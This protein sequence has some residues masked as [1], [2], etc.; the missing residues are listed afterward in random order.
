[1]HYSSKRIIASLKK[2][3][4][5]IVKQLKLNLNSDKEEISMVDMY[6][7]LVMNQRRQISV[8][9]PL[10]M[11]P[12]KYSV[13]VLADLNALGLDG[14]GNPLSVESNEVTD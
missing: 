13:A 7:A 9:G 11:V 12:E 10:P 8:G 1:M 14:Y 4:K 3:L 6:V 5:I 2:Y